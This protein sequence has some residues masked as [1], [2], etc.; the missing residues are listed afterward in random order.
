MVLRVIF[1]LKGYE[2]TGEWRNLH[3]DELYDLY[4]SQ[5]SDKIKI[6][7]RGG[8]RNRYGRQ[9]R[10]TRGALMESDHLEELIIG[11]RTTLN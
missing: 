10:C 2:V 9:E 5:V 8:T 3:N 11:S 6:N 1:G 7:E 4:P